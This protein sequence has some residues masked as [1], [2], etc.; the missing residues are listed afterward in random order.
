[1]LILFVIKEGF[2]L[3][4]FILTFRKGKALPGALLPGKICTTVLFISLIAL[5]LF[6][7]LSTA[8]V[9]TIAVVDTG[10]LIFSFV[11]YIF[12]FFGKNSKVQDL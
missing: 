9:D 8:A 4:A 5:V 11:T 7:G 2:Q 12:A 10:F 6:P 1:V 3:I